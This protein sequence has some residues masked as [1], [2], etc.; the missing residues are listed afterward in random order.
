MINVSL[1]LQQHFSLNSI[2]VCTFAAIPAGYD[3]KN[4][5]KRDKKPEKVLSE[6]Q[7]VGIAI[8]PVF[9][10]IGFDSG[11]QESAVYLLLLFNSFLS[12]KIAH[13]EE[14]QRILINTF[15]RH[16]I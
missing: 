8:A 3:P 12:R 4:A 2:S 15:M 11:I 5:P 6:W 1:T 10:L 9:G 7:G 13:K 14:F 16:F